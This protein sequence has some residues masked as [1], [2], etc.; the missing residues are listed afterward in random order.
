MLMNV[1]AEAILIE[2]SKDT[3]KVRGTE[4][5]AWPGKMISR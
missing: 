3:A 2:F 5:A 1:T 4:E